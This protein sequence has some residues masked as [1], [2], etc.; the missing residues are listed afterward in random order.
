MSK[1]KDVNF[2]FSAKEIAEERTID[3][4]AQEM[5]V[6]AV[7]DGVETVWER[8]AKQ[9]PQCGYGQMGICCTNCAMGPCRIDPF[10]NGPDK[11]VCGAT[12][13]TIVARNLATMLATGAASHSDHGREIVEVAYET[14]LGKTQGYEI[15][16]VEKL[17]RVATEYGIDTDRSKEEIARDLALAM[18]EEFGTIK[19]SIQLVE[20][21][22]E[23]RKELWR[24]LNIMPRSVDREIVEIM[25][26]VHMGV[27]TDYV[28]ILLQ[29]LRASLSDGW[30]G[31]M[32]ATEF[33]DIL[34]GT[35]E[36]KESWVNLGVLS[37]DEVN[38]VLHG[39]NPVLS[40]MIVKASRDPE[41]VALAKEKGA[42]GINPVG[43]CCTGNELLV[44]QGVPIAGNML[45][46]E[47]A[48]VTGAVEAMVVDYQCISPASQRLPSA[49][50]P[51]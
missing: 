45:N 40:E 16:D 35:P 10:G 43:M 38:I 41:L 46:Q 48:L 12:E 42:K 25:H 30:G 51:R 32:M 50:I 33:S 13:D 5:I 29:A 8:L 3:P 34:F 24:N 22:P 4:A 21:A 15:T 26:R 6:K 17:K 1:K 9:Q 47:M 39:H 49:T 18:L 7:E 27:D 2:Y 14:A 28:N 44:R 36:P 31:S 37:H 20:R 11:G 23:P 19:N